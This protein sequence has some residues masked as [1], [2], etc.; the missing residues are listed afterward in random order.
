[1]T[2][3]IRPGRYIALVL[4]RPNGDHRQGRWIREDSELEPIWFLAHADERKVYLVRA[5]LHDR[6]TSPPGAAS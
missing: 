5:I 3:S 6:P 2:V 1:M 4:Q